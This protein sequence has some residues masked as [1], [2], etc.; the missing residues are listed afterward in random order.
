MLAFQVGK[1]V[2]DVFITTCLL[3]SSPKKS[4][5][6]ARHSVVQN[7]LTHALFNVNLI[8]VSDRRLTTSENDAFIHQ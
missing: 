1:I 3:K 8:S 7:L 5:F 2:E 6:I 4:S